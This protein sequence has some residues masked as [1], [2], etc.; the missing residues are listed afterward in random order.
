[1]WYDNN[2]V[3]AALHDYFTE[4]QTSARALIGKLC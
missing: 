2:S 3:E 1:M 4:A